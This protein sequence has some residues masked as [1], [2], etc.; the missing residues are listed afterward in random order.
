MSTLYCFQTHQKRTSDPIT[1]GCEWSKDMRSKLSLFSERNISDNLGEKMWE[2]QR[3]RSK[4]SFL[5]CSSRIPPFEG[6][7]PVWPCLLPIKLYGQCD[8]P[9]ALGA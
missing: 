1:D 9:M 3:V 5:G 2:S 8:L 7:S 6:P 4:N